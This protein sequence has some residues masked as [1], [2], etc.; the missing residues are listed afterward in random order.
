M[1]A[2]NHMAVVF[3]LATPWAGVG[4]VPAPDLSE[5]AHTAH[6]H[7]VLGHPLAELVRYFRHCTVYRWT[8]H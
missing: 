7:C 1:G 3:F 8:V 2:G 4:V 5:L 6:S